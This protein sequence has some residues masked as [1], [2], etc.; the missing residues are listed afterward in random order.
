MSKSPKQNAMIDAY[1]S[2]QRLGLYLHGQAHQDL[3]KII[4]ELEALAAVEEVLDGL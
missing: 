3:M 1:G 2:L 4:G